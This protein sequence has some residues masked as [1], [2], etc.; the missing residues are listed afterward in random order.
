MY[1]LN[2]VTST[3]FTLNT[4]VKTL[5]FYLN[6]R[7]EYQLKHALYSHS[8]VGAGFLLSLVLCLGYYTGKFR[9]YEPAF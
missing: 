7:A 2:L 9:L 3:N 1:N 6:I 8:D 4:V 5:L